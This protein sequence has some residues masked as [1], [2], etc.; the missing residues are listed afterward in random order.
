MDNFNETIR[1]AV[2]PLKEKQYSDIIQAGQGYQI[3]YVED[4]LE[5]GGK[6]L[7]QA[8]EEIQDILYREQVEQKFTDWIA[9]LKENAH[10]K[11]ML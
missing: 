9:S 5:T 2:L 3:I 6:T 8:K 7:D 1:D 11:I 4:I 10:V